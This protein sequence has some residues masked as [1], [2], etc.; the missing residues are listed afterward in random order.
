SNPISFPSSL[1]YLGT[2]ALASTTLTG[3]AV[4]GLKVFTRTYSMSGP[5][6]SPRFEG[7]V[8][9]VVVQA[10][11]KISSAFFPLPDDLPI[12]SNK[13]SLFSFRMALNIATQLVSFTSL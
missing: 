5:T 11:K 3:S 13:N 8:Q 7:S 4:Y 12:D 9:G 2:N 10:R 6:A 1:K